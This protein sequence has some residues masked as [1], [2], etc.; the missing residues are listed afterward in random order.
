MGLN[1]NGQWDEARALLRSVARRV[2]TYAGRDEVLR[3]IVAELEREAEAWS[4]ERLEIERKV[5]YSRS[6][7][8]LKSRASLDGS[9][10]RR[11]P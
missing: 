4:V 5:M 8:S 6:N 7:Y 3:G 9:A 1:R 11:Q 2:R 10:E